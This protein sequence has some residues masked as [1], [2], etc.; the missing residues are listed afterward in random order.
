MNTRRVTLLACAVI[1]WV[2]GLG[3]WGRSS[4]LTKF[5]A[6]TFL[7]LGLVVVVLAFRPMGKPVEH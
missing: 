2:S 3:Y 5:L 4:L 6:P 1:F 7:I